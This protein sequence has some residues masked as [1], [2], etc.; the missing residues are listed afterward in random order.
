MPY[1]CTID[2]LLACL[3]VTHPREV[4]EI[5]LERNTVKNGLLSVGLKMHVLARI[6]GF[7]Q[8][9]E[10]LGGSTEVLDHNVY[11]RYDAEY[12]FVFPPV[13]NAQTMIRLLRCIEKHCDFRIF[14]NPKIQLQVCSPG[15]LDK[16]RSALLGIAFYLGSDTLREYSIEEF[17]T[18]VS[19]DDRYKRGRRIVLYDAGEYGMFERKFAWWARSKW[20]ALLIDPVLPFT[21]AERTD[22]LVGTAS[23]LDIE[24]VNLA[25]TLLLHAERSGLD[26]YWKKLGDEFER[27]CTQLLTCHMLQGLLEAP[28]VHEGGTIDITGDQSFFTALKELTTYAHDEQR[29]L[30]KKTRLPYVREPK[31]GILN[32]VHGLFTGYRAALLLESNTKHQGETQ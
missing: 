28:W 5:E 32:Q 10:R 13:G 25:A 14:G 30:E 18:S 23:P 26:G 9:I 21:T 1:G 11:R 15:R 16:K 4:H 3:R 7:E 17:I 31:P 12:C 8:L 22:I 20:N 27:E 6:P 24:N 19:F 2:K 29:R